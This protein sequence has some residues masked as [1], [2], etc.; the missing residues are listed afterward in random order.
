MTLDPGILFVRHLGKALARSFAERLTLF[1][2]VDAVD[3]DFVLPFVGVEHRDRVA[4][5]HPHD[6]PGNNP[7]SPAA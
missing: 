7:G 1:G 4:V 5:T 2:R 3:A 6:P